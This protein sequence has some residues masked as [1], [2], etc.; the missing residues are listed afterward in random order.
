MRLGLVLSNT[1]VPNNLGGLTACTVTE[2]SSV[3]LLK[4]E[5]IVVR[6]AGRSIDVSPV[7]PAKV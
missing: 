1:P 3:Q 2:L 5:E 6:D 4:A 7:Q